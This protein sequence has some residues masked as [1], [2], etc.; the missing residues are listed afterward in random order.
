MRPS[1]NLLTNETVQKIIDEGFALLEN[2]GIELH[3]QDGKELLLTAGAE[4]DF[5]SQIVRIPEKIA[6][7]AL[8]SCPNSF[9]LYNLRG[10]PVV[11]YGSRQVHF[12]PGSSALTILDRE[13]QRAREA[14]TEDFIHFVKLVETLPQIDAQS[15]AIVCSDVTE[16]IKDLYRLYLALNYMSKPIVTGAFR[17]DTWQIMKDLL[18]TA[19]GGL[20]N[21]QKKPLAI[22][23][24][25]PSPPLKWSNQ[26]CQ[27][28]IDCARFGI[29]LQIVPMPMA[30]ATSPVTL[31]GAVVQHAAECL[32]GITIAQLAGEGARIVWGG[33]PAIF[34]MKNSTTPM[35][36]VGTWMI[37]VAYTQVG[38][39][40]Q[41][42]TQAYL[43]MSDA[44]VVDAQCGLET[45]AGT[46]LAALSGVNMVSGAG[47]MAFENCQ[48][49]EKLVIDADIIGMAKHLSRGI[50]IRDNP[51]A[52]DLIREVGHPSEFIIHDH[53]HRW[54]K[55]E[56]YY[57]SPIID[58]QTAEEWEKNGGLNSWDRAKDQVDKLVAGYGEPTLDQSTRNEM[59]QITT[60]AAQNFGMAKLPPLP[61]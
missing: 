10:D 58:R 38:Q 45:S 6:R 55:D 51:I 22:F 36:A 59:R 32:S 41:L 57:P 40:L 23:D 17:I 24:V 4:A 46:I 37:D 48:S 47:M 35:G 20:T 1:L 60:R 16:E 54:F 2:P 34:D 44:K 30:G 9:A 61:R 39:A 50:Q 42:P 18:V 14:V 53:T 27:N 13:T 19:A 49:F 26:T 52:L 5:G 29:P 31:A 56:F 33:S 25:C 7:S 15:T 28:L 43:G 3:N 12:N 11:Q 21:L 8:E